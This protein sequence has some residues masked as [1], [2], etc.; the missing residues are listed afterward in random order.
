LAA[1][2]A[3]FGIA[4]AHE[5]HDHDEKPVTQQQATT[6]ADRALIALVK[7][8]EVDAAWK[9]THRQGTQPYKVNQA[10]IWMTTYKK[11][12]VDGKGEEKVYI[13]V[14]TIGNYID[15]HTTGKLVAQQLGPH[16]SDRRYF[17]LKH[18]ND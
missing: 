3:T 2:L 4:H 14:D 9:L 12:S 13:F 6:T 15:A 17:M 8:K 11:Q 1:L 18:R 16:A 5:G 10:S 7:N